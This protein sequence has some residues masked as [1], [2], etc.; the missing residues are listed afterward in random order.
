[1]A[2]L[3]D[4]CALCG[5]ILVSLAKAQRHLFTTGGGK[6]RTPGKLQ[7]EIPCDLAT[8]FPYPPLLD[9]RGLG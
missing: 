4:L 1:M 5:K 7:L 2:F 9:R 3:S 6:D 8:G